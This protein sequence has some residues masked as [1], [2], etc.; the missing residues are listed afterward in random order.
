[1]M[2]VQ[3][4]GTVVAGSHM[5]VGALDGNAAIF[6]GAGVGTCTGGFIAAVGGVAGV[7]LAQAIFFGGKCSYTQ[8][9][10]QRDSQDQAD[11]P[12]EKGFAH[13]FGFLLE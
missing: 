11:T 7:M 6:F 2:A 1:M 8:R 10:G 9:C 3:L 5:F 13:G 4:A 12:S